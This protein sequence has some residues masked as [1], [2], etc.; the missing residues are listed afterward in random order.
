MNY[1]EAALKGTHCLATKHVHG[2]KW[3]ISL[4]TETLEQEVTEVYR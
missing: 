4:V 1:K 3:R 2:A